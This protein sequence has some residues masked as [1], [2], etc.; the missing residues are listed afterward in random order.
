M[1]SEKEQAFIGYHMSNSVLEYLHAQLNLFL[2]PAEGDCWYYFL[3]VKE[4]TKV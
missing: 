4:E 3:F 1:K 2:T